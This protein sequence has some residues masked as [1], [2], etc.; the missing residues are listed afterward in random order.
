MMTM[1]TFMKTSTNLKVNYIRH[2]IQPYDKRTVLKTIIKYK[3][4][5]QLDDTKNKRNIAH[6][7]V[8]RNKHGTEYLIDAFALSEAYIHHYPLIN[9]A[10]LR[11]DIMYLLTQIPDYRLKYERM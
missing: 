5:A 2:Q 1:D 4:Y 3:A 11:R 8:Q 9:M 6:L 10:A 7:I